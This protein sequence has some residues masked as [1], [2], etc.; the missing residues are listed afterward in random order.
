MDVVGTH[1]F[2]GPVSFQDFENLRLHPRQVQID[3]SITPRESDLADHIGAF[4]IEPDGQIE[5]YTKRH[6]WGDEKAV[7]V[8]GDR[9]PL[10]VHGSD[11]VALAI[12]ADTAHAEHV[13]AA[14]G[15][16]A[17][18]YVTG[19]FFDSASYATSAARLEG[20]ASRHAIAVAMANAGGPA[21]GFEAAGGSAI[22]SPTGELVARLD[23]VGSGL[24]I[25]RRDVGGWR[26]EAVRAR[27]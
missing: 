25:A 20:Y 10:L 2:D 24:V 22:W 21:T 18:L 17:T 5:I 12:C 19:V 1:H 16:G 7:F 13:E 26:G 14:V 9:D 11:R 8:P 27:R 6:L 15:R 23:G 4:A 3:V